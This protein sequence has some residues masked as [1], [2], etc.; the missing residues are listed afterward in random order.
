MIRLCW[1]A[2]FLLAAVW[3]LIVKRVEGIKSKFAWRSLSISQSICLKWTEREKNEKSIDI[4]N[5]MHDIE[6]T[7]V[8]FAMF[9]QW[10]ETRNVW[11]CTMARATIKNVK[12]EASRQ[13]D[14]IAR[15]LPT[16]FAKS[17]SAQVNG[18]VKI[19]SG[20][21]FA[22]VVRSTWNDSKSQHQN[23]VNTPQWILLARRAAARIG[24]KQLI[25]DQ[26]LDDR[27]WSDTSS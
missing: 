15:L 13:G 6:T 7:Q 27:K 3:W 16:S 21:V 1:A 18:R 22:C 9:E 24:T 11:N 26:E 14:L 2:L 10:S 25:L 12:N 19:R 8:S 20:F 5:D 4:P 23:L 17:S